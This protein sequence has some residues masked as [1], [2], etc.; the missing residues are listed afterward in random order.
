[1]GQTKTTQ[2]EIIFIITRLNDNRI[3]IQNNN[4]QI[5][6]LEDMFIKENIW[7]YH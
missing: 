1:M 2:N 5:S 7:K 6:F 3:P 4:T